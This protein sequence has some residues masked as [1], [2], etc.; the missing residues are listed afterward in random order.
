MG[1]RLSPPTA[2]WLLWQLGNQ[3]PKFGLGPGP[4]GAGA[5]VALRAERHREFGHVV[6][7]RSVDNDNEIVLSGRQ[8]DFL[9]LD[10]HFFC[11]LAGGLSALGSVLDGTDALIGPRERQYEHR[12]LILRVVTQECA[13]LE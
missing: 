6:P 7:V 9:D 8:I 1:A 10:S 3:L 4:R 11:E 2:L 5:H 13:C 12:H